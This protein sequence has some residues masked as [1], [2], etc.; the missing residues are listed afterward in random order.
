[1]PNLFF[2][3]KINYSANG[4]RPCPTGKVPRTLESSYEV[5]AATVH[6]GPHFLISLF[7]SSYM[8]FL[9][10]FCAKLESTTLI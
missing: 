5:I 4:C 3:L 2:I 10:F 6:E 8:L 1:M 9:A 7:S